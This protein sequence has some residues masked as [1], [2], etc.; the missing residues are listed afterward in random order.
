MW[1]KH[2]DFKQSFYLAA[3]FMLIILITS[4]VVNAINGTTVENSSNRVAL[5][6]LPGSTNRIDGFGIGSPHLRVGWQGLS[7]MLDAQQRMG[8]Y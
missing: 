7:E 1:G 3:V 6:T 2:M 8:V 5:P 4:P